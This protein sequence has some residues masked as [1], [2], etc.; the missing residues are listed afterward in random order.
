MSTTI[1]S[2]A[3]GVVAAATIFVGAYVAFPLESVSV[4]G[5]EMLP[6]SKVEQ[7]VSS[8]TSLLTLN[9]ASLKEEIEASPWVEDATI[10]RDW[11][12]REVI[13]DVDERVA[14]LRASVDGKTEILASDGASLPGDGD[15]DLPV[16]EL[17]SWQT[18]E[19]L[20][21]ARA[22]EDG[23]AGLESVDS[24]GVEGISATVAGRKILL[25]DSVKTEQIEALGD[26][27][28]E[29]PEAAVFDLRS[30]GR[31]IV[32]A[33]GGTDRAD[34]TGS[35]GAGSSPEPETPAG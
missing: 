29:N 26:V 7:L 5:T 17:E 12:K 10:S 27:F 22:I 25:S 34:S 8:R 11:Q 33:S 15:M 14:V 19:V 18:S 30:P 4:E 6:K 31:I 21:V 16:V 2:V 28:R 24:V 1:V 20:A 3:A 32:S 9:A 35:I 23:G 13:V